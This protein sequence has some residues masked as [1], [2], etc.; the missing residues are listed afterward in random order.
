MNTAVAESV[1]HALLKSELPEYAQDPEVLK[2]INQE[3]LKQSKRDGISQNF[4]PLLKDGLGRY[5]LINRI[6]GGG[7]GAVF[8]AVDR[9]FHPEARADVAIKIFEGLSM[10]EGVRARSVDHHAVVKVLDEGIDPETSQAYIVYEFLDG[11]RLDKWVTKQSATNSLTGKQIAQL[12]IKIC[13]GV[14][15]IHNTSLIH[16]DLKPGNVIMLGDRPV[17]ADF[18]IAVAGLG[19]WHPAGTPASMAPEQR[20]G[21]GGTAL[22]DIYGLGVIFHYLLTNDYPDMGATNH[23]DKKLAAIAQHCL[24][25]HPQDRYPSPAH[26]QADLQAYLE[27][28]PVSV[29][30][31]SPLISLLSIGRRH[32]G[33]VAA[34]ILLL[35]AAGLMALHQQ[36]IIENIRQD[37]IQVLEDLE[38][39]VV[40]S[41]N[42]AIANANTQRIIHATILDMKLRSTEADPAIFWAIS[43]LAAKPGWKDWTHQ[44]LVTTEGVKTL[45]AEVERQ[46]NL[47]DQ[48]KIT[49][50]YWWL[51]LAKI[52]KVIPEMDQQTV[53]ST[54]ETALSKMTQALGPTDPIVIELAQDLKSFQQSTQ[55]QVVEVNTD[56]S[57]PTEP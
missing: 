36:R 47:P 57:A 32:P 49:V 30:E 41:N 12:M 27:H 18:G 11:P 9:K 17:I 39:A 55:S 6:G 20:T 40:H 3:L 26:V 50:A 15:A 48:S 33:L 4:G 13:D 24:E 37:N 16:R 44:A 8:H 38:K 31:Q 34:M 46:S 1:V 21:R 28:R 51:L 25:Q 22:V 5:E 29:Y 45:R 52:E 54:Y 14:Q 23:E 2:L 42:V 56:A 7:Q 19:D 53:Q 35:A 10:Q 43:K